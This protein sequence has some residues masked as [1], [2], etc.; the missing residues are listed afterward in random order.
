MGVRGPHRFLCGDGGGG[1]GW[2][3]AAGEKVW[4]GPE[5]PNVEERGGWTKGVW[6]GGRL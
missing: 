4:D 2:G 5:V 3:L 6:A 1:G